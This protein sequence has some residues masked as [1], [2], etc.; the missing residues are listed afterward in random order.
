MSTLKSI[1]L[2]VSSLVLCLIL[3]PGVTSAIE[4]EPNGVSVIQE[5]EDESTDHSSLRD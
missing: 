5:V 2:K 3:F 4:L 1:H